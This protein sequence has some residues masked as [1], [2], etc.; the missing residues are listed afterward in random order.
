MLSGLIDSAGSYD[1]HTKKRGDRSL[2]SLEWIRFLQ[3]DRNEEAKKKGEEVKKTV[4]L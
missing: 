3:E 4:F 2:E 1:T